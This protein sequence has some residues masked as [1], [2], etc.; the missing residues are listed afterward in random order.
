[1]CQW[2]EMVDTSPS[3]KGGNG[4]LLARRALQKDSS[5]LAQVRAAGM[6]C[7]SN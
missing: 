5:E 1:M 4:R 7:D 6:R 3:P 2:Y